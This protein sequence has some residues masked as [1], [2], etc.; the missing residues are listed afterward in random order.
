MTS[1]PEP[2]APP[3]KYHEPAFVRGIIVSL[4]ELWEKDGG[5]GG[6]FRGELDPA[7]AVA[8]HTHAHHA[9]RM[10]RALLILD[11]ATVGAETVP[12]VRLILECGVT[13]AWLLLTEGSGNSMIRRGSQDRRLALQSIAGLGRNV[14]ESLE[15][16]AAKVEELDKAGAS[17]SWAFEQRCQALHGGA[18]LYVLYRVLSSESH[19][20][21]HVADLYVA[22]DDRSAIGVGFVADLPYE[23]R[24]SSLGVAACLLFVA[25]N[26][27]ELARSKPHKTTQLRKIAKRLGVG[28]RIVGKDGF[29]HPSR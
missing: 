23:T 18:E 29:E 20:G 8:I 24:I 9:V 14:G 21:M 16:A 5:A 3:S 11:D 28:S 17:K 22:N 13:A 27:D 10:A 6:D 25:I 1:A 26:A 12:I 4:C 19:A 2:F 15:E 7:R